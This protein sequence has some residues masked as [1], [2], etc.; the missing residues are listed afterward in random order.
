ML[1]K[2]D[3]IKNI[4]KKDKFEGLN[5]KI[6]LKPLKQKEEVDKITG[7]TR[8]VITEALFILKFGGELTHAGLD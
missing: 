7:K 6:Q 3:M 8:V 5:R 4:L 2:Y 1:E